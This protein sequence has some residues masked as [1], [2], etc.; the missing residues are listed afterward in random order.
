MGESGVA[1]VA[2]QEGFGALAISTDDR[3]VWSPLVE[4]LRSAG[5]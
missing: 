5:G 2:L 3:V 4:E 1:W